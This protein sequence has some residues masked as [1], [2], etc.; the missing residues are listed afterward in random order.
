MSTETSKDFEDLL[1]FV[2]ENRGFDFTGYKRP[3]L[4]RRFER[5]MQ[6]LGIDDFAGY[7]TRLEE[8]PDE[9]VELFN[10]ILINVT[11]FFRDPSSWEYLA[12]EI[13]PRVV[14]EKPEDG[15]IRVWSPGCASGDEA[16]S[17]GMLLLEAL[18]ENEF[19][20]RVKI[21]ATD[22]DEQALT[23]GRHA[24]YGPKAVADVPEELREKYFDRFD[25]RFSVRKNLRRGVI[26][27]RHAVI[28]DPPISRVDLLVCRNTLMYFDAETQGRIIA[29]FHFALNDGGYL[30][31]GKSE[32]LVTR[33]NLFVPIDLKRR[34]FAR[35]PGTGPRNHV[36]EG[37]NHAAPVAS[38]DGDFG[39]AGLHQAPVPQ[40]VVDSRG[41]LVRANVQARLSFGLSQA[42]VGKPL[43]ELEISYKPVELRSRL[44][45]VHA[46]RR[47]VTVREIE[48]EHD[49]DTRVLDVTVTP[50]A[51]G[52]GTDLGAC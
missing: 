11:S 36:R 32:A 31:L 30:F 22:V 52:D 46:E 35:A 51:A 19:R 18:G 12:Q 44:D 23:Q 42:D 45:E 9:F 25:T 40:I 49:G 47:P 10:T 48:W 37:W 14:E 3:S 5:R 43:H 2:K 29:N 41:L 13:V 20:E 17:I 7:R 38:V 34:V 16:Y 6:S 15:D 27:G 4:T 24:M 39:D 1:L 33:S 26:F 21:Y 28:Q 8:D 50:L